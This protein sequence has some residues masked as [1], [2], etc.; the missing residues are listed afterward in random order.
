MRRY[1]IGAAVLLSL[2]L[3]VSMC[4]TYTDNPDTLSSVELA[5]CK[6]RR[7]C[8]DMAHVKDMA[9]I[10]D[11]AQAKDLAQPLVRDLATPPP[12]TDLAIPPRDL[13]VPRDLSTPP[14]LAVTMAC[15]P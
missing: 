11:L 1:V 8:P 14:D 10:K 5:R 4:S 2:I 7:N 13:S 12:P 15:G 9:Q 6:N 3:V